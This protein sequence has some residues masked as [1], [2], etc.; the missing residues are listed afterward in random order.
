VSGSGV[1]RYIFITL[2]S[3]ALVA[4]GGC[5]VHEKA[6]RDSVNAA[7]SPAGEAAFSV[8]D[9]DVGHHVSGDRRLSDTT[10]TFTPADTLF[11]SVHTTG[12]ATSGAVVG[13]WTS[14]DGTVLDE[15]T[16]NV[17]NSGDA[18][19]AFNLER[20]TNFAP[21]TYTLHVLVDGREV[22]SKDVDVK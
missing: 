4:L 5:K 7:V 1:I 6:T 15:R 14:A 19:L 9:I 21:G 16:Q 11:A 20:P 22:A 3:C 18:Y 10:K 17:L 2:G 12:S 8:V 13:R